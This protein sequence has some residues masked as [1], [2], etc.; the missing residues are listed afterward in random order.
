MDGSCRSYEKALLNATCPLHIEAEGRPPVLAIGHT[1][2]AGE[3]L[4]NTGFDG[5]HAFKLLQS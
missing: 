4:F 1:D 2:S 3:S 5:N